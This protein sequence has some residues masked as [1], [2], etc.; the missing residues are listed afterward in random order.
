[1]DSQAEIIEQS[2]FIQPVQT[3]PLDLKIKP[4]N[5]VCI[6]KPE[7]QIEVVN[8]LESIAVEVLSQ[9]LPFSTVKTETIDVSPHITPSEVEIE[10]NLTQEIMEGTN[11]RKKGEKRVL[12]IRNKLQKVMRR[13]KRAYKK[14]KKITRKLHEMQRINQ[15]K[16]DIY[17]SKPTAEELKL[18]ESELQQ[19]LQRR[20]ED[21]KLRRER[22][23]KRKRARSNQILAKENVNTVQESDQNNNSD[24]DRPPRLTRMVP[25]RTVSGRNDPP[26]RVSLRIQQRAPTLQAESPSTSSTP[27]SLLPE[28]TPCMVPARRR[29]LRTRRDTPFHMHTLN[30]PCNLCCNQ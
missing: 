17:A 4:N 2:N 29:S 8:K 21:R 26:R 23:E 1:M 16:S 13:H 25:P 14:L 27:P 19:I 9:L 10:Q 11:R 30:A 28:S 20:K 6:V 12:K 18:A 24:E 7:D 22:M 15:V 3:V 5:L